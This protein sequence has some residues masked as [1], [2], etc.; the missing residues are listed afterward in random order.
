MKRVAILGFGL[1]GKSLFSYLKK[2]EDFEITV[3][4]RDPKIKIARGIKKVL[5]KSY[6]KNLGKFDLVFRSPGVPYNLPELKKASGRILSLTRLFFEE[7]KKKENIRV[8]GI[9]GSAGKTTT[10]T[11]LYKILKHAGRKVFLGGNIGKSPLDYLEKLDSGS[12]VVMELSSFQLQDLNYSPD[13]ALVLDIFEEHLDKHKNFRE[14]FDAKSN[15]ARHQKKSDAIIYFADNKYSSAIAKKSIGKKIQVTLESAKKF[16]FK[17]KVPGDY[18][19]KNAMAA[20]AA[21]RL[22]GV[23]RETIIETVN[24]FK[25]IKHRLEFVRNLNGVGY[26]NNSKATNVG[27]AI[28]GIDAFLEKKIVLAGGYNKKLD[29]TP[30]V[31]RLA[32]RDIRSAVY[33]GVAAG[34]LERISKLLGFSRYS[35]TAGLESAIKEA[36]KISIKGDI[37]ILSPGTASFDEFSNYEERGDKFRKWVLEL[38]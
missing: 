17:L 5:G 7:I 11:L 34:E 1:E 27:S 16:G 31:R 14:Y 28:G 10:A 15:I 13:V 20:G 21:A 6:L 25:G 33:F 19:Y 23:K 12:T 35:K 36:H 9:T 24:N 37:T 3:L 26:Y 22:F 32:R 18:N 38:K 29:L 2:E 30:L 8:V 4:D